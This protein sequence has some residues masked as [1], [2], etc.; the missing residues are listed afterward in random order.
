[1]KLLQPAQLAQL[2][3][4]E[5]CTL[6]A[7]RCAARSSGAMALAVAVAQWASLVLLLLES[8][9]VAALA[10]AESQPLESQPGLRE[11]ALAADGLVA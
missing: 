9:P 4:A 10:S 6:D 1:V 5:P 11:A 8:V 2:A 3:R 7:V